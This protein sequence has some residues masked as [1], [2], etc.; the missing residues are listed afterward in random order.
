MDTSLLTGESVPATLQDAD[1]VF[2]GT[3]VVEGEGEAI[4]TA[5]GRSTR[6]ADIA[7]LTI[8]SH[9]PTFR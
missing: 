3:F 7:R 2:A 1:P 6:L 5:T 8:E 9:A 4:V